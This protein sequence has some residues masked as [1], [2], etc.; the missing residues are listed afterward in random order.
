MKS[1]EVEV[2]LSKKH[3]EVNQWIIP[4]CPVCGKIHYHGA[5]DKKDETDLKSGPQGGRS[6]H[7]A[8]DLSEV[9]QFELVWK[10]KILPDNWTEKTI[11]EVIE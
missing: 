5:G 9:P 7:C 3:R 1:L 10:G 4:G 11:K 2:Y 6:P 8:L